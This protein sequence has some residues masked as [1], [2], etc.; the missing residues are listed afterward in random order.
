MTTSEDGS[1]CICEDV[2]V[3]VVK[4]HNHTGALFGGKITNTFLSQPGFNYQSFDT[5]MCV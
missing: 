4:L 2:T 5:Y 1:N 3:T